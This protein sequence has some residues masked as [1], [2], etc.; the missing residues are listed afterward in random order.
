LDGTCTPDTGVPSTSCPTAWTIGY[1][2]VNT[3]QDGTGNLLAPTEAI[4]G[5][6]Q[7]ESEL[8]GIFPADSDAD[9][10][11]DMVFALFGPG[12]HLPYYQSKV[13]RAGVSSLPAVDGAV[14]PVPMYG[15]SD[16]DD[17][18]EYWENTDER[19][20]AVDGSAS[21][22][23]F[24]EGEQ[25][26]YPGGALDGVYWDS[27]GYIYVTGEVGVSWLGPEGA[28]PGWDTDYDDASLDLDSLPWTFSYDY[29]SDAPF[30]TTV[31]TDIAWCDDCDDG[32]G[33]G[34]GIGIVALQD[35]GAAWID[36]DD[37][38]EIDCHFESWGAQ[39]R[40]VAQHYDAS[41]G[42]EVVWV[43]T[44]PQSDV[45]SQAL[46]RW[47]STDGLY[48]YAG[49]SEYITG[50]GAFYVDGTN[51]NS[52]MCIDAESRPTTD[53]P[54]C[55]AL[56]TGTILTESGVDWG[57]ITDID[58]LR[59]DVALVG[60]Y[61]NDDDASI[62]GGIVIAEGE[63]ATLDLTDIST[64]ATL[65][66]CTADPDDLFLNAPT[67]TLSPR[68][69]HD[70]CGSDSA[71]PCAMV[72]ALEDTSGWTTD[73]DDSDLNCGL[74]YVEFYLSGGAWTAD[75]TSLPLE[76]EDPTD[77]TDTDC[78]VS[79]ET[80]DGAVFAPWDFYNVYSW[81]D[82]TDAARGG[83]CKH[84]VLTAT[85]G[86]S[87]ELLAPDERPMG[88]EDMAPH[89]HLANLFYLGANTARLTDCAYYGCEPP[90]L[91]VLG[92]RW[93]ADLGDF[94]WVGPRAILQGS[95][96]PVRQISGIVYETEDEWVENLVV[97]SPAAGPLGI[98][99][100]W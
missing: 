92:K 15:F 7:P 22:M 17:D 45:R 38:G 55:D 10:N 6:V 69:D 3:Y 64:S 4:D 59:S 87:E 2:Q 14:D 13:W 20:A 81:A 77:P 65:G 52:W 72:V 44:A 34:T 63:T 75:W 100:A 43:G 76:Y 16:H 18:N 56:A 96:L 26:Y 12:R 5:S 33:A 89:P 42:E 67:I 19:E 1:S 54:T 71:N 28:S 39:G 47:N 48:C 36:E 73:L 41:T 32:S 35:L 88:F 21:W 23:D 9:G 62:Q 70:T 46:F 94:E 74:F 53:W 58:V 99:L 37:E 51:G 91:V 57:H 8:R 68:Y 60:F 98:S 30:Q 82:S 31:A 95:G 25:S 78:D 93:R 80:L 61:R 79:V 85:M 50:D 86:Q 27:D 90:S 66:S 11:D 49:T 84:S 40:A 97:S 29:A 83:V 24:Q